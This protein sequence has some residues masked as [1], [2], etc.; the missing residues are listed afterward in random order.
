MGIF[1]RI[2]GLATL[3]AFG[4]LRV[5]IA[6]LGL[7]AVIGVVWAIAVAVGLLLFGF[8]LPLQIA[9]FFGAVTVWHWPVLPAVIVAAPRLILVLPGLI[10]TFLA[11][12]RHPRP[13]WSSFKP[14]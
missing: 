6:V 11:N 4:L 10:S 13:R 8:M 5:W 7:A 1:I 12:R 14:A 2:V 3:A 9:V